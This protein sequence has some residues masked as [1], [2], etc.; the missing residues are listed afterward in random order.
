MSILAHK[1][2]IHSILGFV[3]QLCEFPPDFQKRF[4]AALRRMV[5]GPGN[6]ISHTDLTHLKQFGFP[7]EFPDPFVMGT[8]AKLRVICQ[9]V[10]HAAKLHQELLQVQSE[11]LHRPFKDWHCRSFAA[12][13]V[14]NLERAQQA[15]INVNLIY[16]NAKKARK[17]MKL[18]E[19]FLA[20]VRWCPPTAGSGAPA[21]W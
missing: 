15:G 3:A 7:A 20:P 2:Y 4:E 19:Q 21:G 11:Y 17:K 9:A 10:P 18:Q 6:W 14:Q 12:V 16:R 8:A 13:L 5:P 1:F